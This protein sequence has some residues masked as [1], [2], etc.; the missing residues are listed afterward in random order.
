MMPAM[1]WLLHGTM[2]PAVSDALKRHGHDVR[3]MTAANLD[4]NLDTL[5][6]LK[7][8]RTAQLD[9]V[10]TDARMTTV[11][12][13]E[14]LWFGRTIVYLQLDGGDVEQDDAIDRLFARYGRLAPGRLYTVTAN[15]VKV[16]QL[17]SRH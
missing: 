17:P 16:R 13:A 5:E 7:S 2:T 15:R 1:R 4:A 6:V 9:I 12:F 10:T 3:D 11:P 14:D 8:A